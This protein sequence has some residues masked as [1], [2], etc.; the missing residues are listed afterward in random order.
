MKQ[1]GGPSI[2]SILVLVGALGPAPAFAD[3]AV[4]VGV[5]SDDGVNP[6][7]NAQNFD[8][9][10]A[11]G[12]IL[13][14]KL[15]NAGK[16]SMVDRAHIDAVTNEQKNAVSGG[17]AAANAV[18]VG[19]MVGANFMIVGRIAHL[20]KVS[21]SNAGIGSLLSN[22]GISNAGTAQDKYRLDIELQ[23]IDATTGRIVKAFSYD[24]AKVANGVAVAG[25]LPALPAG[26]TGPSG[27][28]ANP[29][30]SNQQFASSIVGQLLN[31]AG[32]ELAKKISA[33]D[34]SAP[35]TV[36]MTVQ[37]I[38]VDGTNV[39]LNKGS[40]DGVTVGMFLSAYHAVTA[41]DPE[42]GKDLVTN[43]P[44]GQLEVISVDPNSS[45]ARVVSGKVTTPG[46]FATSP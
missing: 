25:V 26:V 20:D 46:G 37:L 2:F 40:A 35:P 43:V 45:V 27:T 18:Q 44:D 38:A 16:L 3:V 39:I 10:K 33:V 24:E 22:F 29:G 11:F 9:G 1:L 12:D 42:S 14:T 23:L 19:H 4:A 6:M 21:S 7:F 31:S 13:T 28:P 41:K 5:I 15:V 30:Y 17:F 8:P 34:L 32:D 36:T